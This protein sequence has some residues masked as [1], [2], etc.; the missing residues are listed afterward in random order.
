MRNITVDINGYVTP[1]QIDD[2]QLQ[3]LS[4]VSVEG[5]KSSYRIEYGN[6]LVE[7]GGVKEIEATTVKEGVIEGVAT[8]NIDL[9][10]IAAQATAM[11]VVAGA[12]ALS[13]ENAFIR[14]DDT[15]LRVYATASASAKHTI[16][17]MWSVKGVQNGY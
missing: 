3:N 12:E 7:V 14:I 5:D 6:G 16:P 4:Q 2:D 8:I 13:G 9:Q 15:Q 11:N 1:L 10:I 17:V